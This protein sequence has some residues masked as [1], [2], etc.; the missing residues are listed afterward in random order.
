MCVA[1]MNLGDLPAVLWTHFALLVVP[2]FSFFL[3]LSLFFFLCFYPLLLLCCEFITTLLVQM[4]MH[5]SAVHA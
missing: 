1:W 4:S 5:N 2:L 3:H